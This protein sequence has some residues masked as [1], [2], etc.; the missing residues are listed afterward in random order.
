MCRLSKDRLVGVFDH[1]K[2]LGQVRSSQPFETGHTSMFF[3]VLQKREQKKHII[4]WW[5]PSIYRWSKHWCTTL[6]TKIRHPQLLNSSVFVSKAH[7]GSARHGAPAAAWKSGH[8]LV[9]K[10]LETNG[11]RPKN[12]MKHICVR[13]MLYESELLQKM[14]CF[15]I[16]NQWILENKQKISCNDKC[17]NFSF[18]QLNN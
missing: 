1:A 10:L 9:R 11:T 12:T 18:E 15:L 14:T 8:H 4:T 2:N 13:Q 5:N 17:N 16:Q 6:M 3:S 7:H